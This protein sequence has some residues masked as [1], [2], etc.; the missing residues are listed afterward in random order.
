MTEKPTHKSI[1]AALVAAQGEMGSAKKS[2]K[3]PHFKSNYADLQSVCDA[4]MPALNAAGIAVIQPMERVGD[5]WV[6]VTR[7]IHAESG[8]TLETPVPLIFGK[9]DMQG[10]GSAQTYARRYGLMTL[11]G[12]APEDDDGNKAAQGVKDNGHHKE[13]TPPQ[14]PAEPSRAAIEAVEAKIA[15]AG[16]T[17][18]LKAVWESLGD[19][20]KDYPPIRD[21]VN[22]R[23]KVLAEAPALDDEIKY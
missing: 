6:V 19:A 2:A 17:D 10:L 5:A 4:V 23:K 16:T 20:M 21:A 7:F 8:E 15:Q 1:A 3:N 22:A 12:I 9:N 13:A 18:A 11:S 14:Q